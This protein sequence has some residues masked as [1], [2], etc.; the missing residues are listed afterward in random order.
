VGS[1]SVGEWSKAIASGSGNVDLSRIIRYP[2]GLG[3][4]VKKQYALAFLQ[5][6]RTASSS[7]SSTKQILEMNL[8]YFRY[9]GVT[10][11][12]QSVWT[13]AGMIVLYISNSLRFKIM[14]L[15]TNSVLHSFELPNR[16]IKIVLP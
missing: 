1:T 5:S 15:M 10:W 7:I 12:L 3:L 4:G 9:P 6:L 8:G 14:N 2:T 13:L 16:A 11:D